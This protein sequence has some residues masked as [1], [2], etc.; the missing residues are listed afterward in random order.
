VSFTSQAAGDWV[1]P[2]KAAGEEVEIQSVK[3]NIA[4]HELVA[5]AVA[6]Q[7]SVRIAN[8]S[9]ARGI[10]PG[11]IVE[12]ALRFQVS[13]FVS[14]NNIVFETEI[15]NGQEWIADAPVTISVAGVEGLDAE[16]QLIS[17]IGLDRVGETASGGVLYR[18]YL[19]KELESV[20]LGDTLFGGWTAKGNKA[21]VEGTI[22]YRA[23]VLDA[24]Q[25]SVASGDAS[26]DERDVFTTGVT[27]TGE[28]LEPGSF[29]PTGVT[30]Q[31]GSGTRMQV[32][33]GRLQTS[34]YAINGQS[35]VG[36]RQAVAGDLVTYRITRTVNSSDIEDLVLNDYLPLPVHS[37]ASIK[38]ADAKAAPS[39]GSLQLGP[40][41]TFHALLGSYPKATLD[42]ANNRVSL[43]YGDVDSDKNETTVIDL[44][45]TVVVEDRPF[46]DGLWLTNLANATYGSSNNGSASQNAL[47]DIQY[48]RP[49][50]NIVKG[51]LS[52]DNPRGIPTPAGSNDANVSG[53]DAADRVRFQVLVTNTGLS[54]KGAFDTLIKDTLPG[55]YIIPASGLDLKVTDANGREWKWT[56][57][58]PADTNPLFG[59]G[60]RFLES[61]PGAGAAA[62]TNQVVISYT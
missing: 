33:N 13:D 24:F 35:V 5:K 4:A 47:T 53:V 31:D 28:T 6:V 43:N 50:L 23:K 51:I 7:Q 55:G 36:Q 38:W 20:G 14:L 25:R 58:N 34:V 2:A 48:T 3:T 42:V 27:A 8:D 41:D 16:K 45:I 52:T 49:V 22:T 11:D 54:A 40:Q 61:V 15:P 59:R 56:A 30:A 1:K 18:V 29:N 44:L 17:Q 10:G 57:E 32:P 60:L 19:S 12:Y 62:G 37:V 46:A 26:I 21:G 39:N 9:N